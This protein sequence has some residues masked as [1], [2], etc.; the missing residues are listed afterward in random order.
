MKQKFK[1][2]DKII[3]LYTYD[4]GFITRVFNRYDGEILYGVDWI[5]LSLSGSNII[6]WFQD[7]LK[8]D[9]AYHIMMDRD[10]ILDKLLN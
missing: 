9:G 5:D 10:T 2:G 4:T 7:T 6:I 1:I 3:H 8:L